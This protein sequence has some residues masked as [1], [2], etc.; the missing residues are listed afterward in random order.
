MSQSIDLPL[1][2][3]D[4]LYEPPLVDS[5]R[6]DDERRGYVVQFVPSDDISSEPTE[7]IMLSEGDPEFHRMDVLFGEIGRL[8]GGDKIISR[9]LHAGGGNYTIHFSEGTHTELANESPSNVVHEVSDR[10]KQI[11][12]SAQAAFQMASLAHA[13]S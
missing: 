4:R 10:L 1:D 2:D 8:M 13:Q 6:H 3:D 11:A 12:D 9:I 7:R 5:I